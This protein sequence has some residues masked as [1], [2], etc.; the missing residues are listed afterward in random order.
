MCKNICV[1]CACILFEATIN[2]GEDDREYERSS[3]R[4]KVKDEEDEGGDESDNQSD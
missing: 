1:W 3:K 2:E 4:R